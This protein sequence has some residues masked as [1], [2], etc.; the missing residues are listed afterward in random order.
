M[1]FEIGLARCPQ[2]KKAILW[3]SDDEDHRCDDCKCKTADLL[4]SYPVNV[5]NDELKKGTF[6]ILLEQSKKAKVD[7]LVES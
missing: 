4:A 7:G 5:L 3:F 1:M 6:D 2:C